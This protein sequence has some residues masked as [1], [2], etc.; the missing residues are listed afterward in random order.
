L[1]LTNA[2]KQKRWRDRRNAL[3]KLG[4]RLRNQDKPRA[5]LAEIAKLKAEIKRLRRKQKIAHLL[6][7]ESPIAPRPKTD[8][9]GVSAV[10]RAMRSQWPISGPDSSETGKL[11]RCPL[12]R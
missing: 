7:E 8:G 6:Q 5:L 11:S 9:N 10:S 3:A 1:A 4:E 12:L 2:E